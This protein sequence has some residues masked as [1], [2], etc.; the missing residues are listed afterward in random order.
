MNIR[1]YA[2]CINPSS[3]HLLPFQT[4]VKLHASH[5]K[6]SRP[7]KW[8]TF[9]RSL[10]TI[11]P[12]SISTLA[13]HAEFCIPVDDALNRSQTISVTS[14]NFSKRDTKKMWLAAKLP[15]DDIAFS[16]LNTIQIQDS[17]LV[18]TH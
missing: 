7:P 4:I 6:I 12:D 10:A 16:Y 13:L 11:D 14:Y 17:Q 8:Y 2:Q 1:S 9:L 3:T 18:I 15:T 5:L